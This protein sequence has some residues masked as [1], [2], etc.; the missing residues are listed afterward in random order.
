MLLCIHTPCA[1][2]FCY[3]GRSV[4]KQQEELSFKEEKLYQ[5]MSEKCAE[6]EGRKTALLEEMITVEVQCCGDRDSV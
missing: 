2:I 6:F 1:V 4:A 3:C 5:Q